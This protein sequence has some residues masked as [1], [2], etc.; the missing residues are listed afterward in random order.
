MTLPAAQILGAGISYLGIEYLGGFSS[1]FL[2]GGIGLTAVSLIC[3]WRGWLM[4]EEYEEEEE[5]E[6]EAEEEEEE[7]E[8]V[9]P[10]VFEVDVE[11]TTDDEFAEREKMKRE[12]RAKRKE[13]RRETRRQAKL[14]GHE[15]KKRQGPFLLP[16]Q[17]SDA[18]TSG[19]EVSTSAGEHKAQR[20]RAALRKKTSDLRLYGDGNLSAPEVLPSRKLTHR[21]QRQNHTLSPGHKEKGYMTFDERIVTRRHSAAGRSPDMVLG[22]PQGLNEAK[23]MDRRSKQLRKINAERRR[24]KRHKA[25]KQE[26]AYFQQRHARGQVW[27]PP[28][29]DS[30]L[31]IAN[32]I[33]KKMEK[34]RLLTLSQQ[35]F[36][37]IAS[38]RPGAV[39]LVLN[40]TKSDGDNTD[41]DVPSMSPWAV[42]PTVMDHPDLTDLHLG[43]PARSA[44]TK[45]AASPTSDSSSS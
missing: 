29:A 24:A 35:R 4:L 10:E 36:G 8:E 23:L 39:R 30:E 44:P 11:S 2:V 25:L 19:T 16:R 41:N 15:H 7:V 37:L 32:E 9:P 6:E 5:A 22:F 20:R 38:K 14:L 42:A 33:K 13:E 43:A 45:R 3:F 26:A 18:H 12:W 31:T 1:L 17:K 21:S 27:L 40:R 34:A 28:A